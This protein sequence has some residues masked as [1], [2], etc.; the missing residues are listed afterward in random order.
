MGHQ[1]KGHF[2]FQVHCQVTPSHKVPLDE[3]TGIV[4]Q[5]IE[6]PAYKRLK[7]ARQDGSLRLKGIG[8]AGWLRPA[9]VNRW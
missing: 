3:A 9:L 5:H 4:H 8:K 6:L 2:L 1:I 7:K